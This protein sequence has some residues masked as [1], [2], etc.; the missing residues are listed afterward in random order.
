MQRSG[1]KIY[2][3]CDAFLA[4]VQ[5]KNA[6]ATVVLQ[7][8]A[9]VPAINAVWRPGTVFLRSSVQENFGARGRERR[10]V[11][12]EGS[13]EE[14]FGRDIGIDPRGAQNIDLNVP[15]AFLEEFMR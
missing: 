4:S 9:N 6:V 5:H 3:P 13:I 12:I 14:H 2:G 7:C 1:E 15:M 10:F 8:R 11:I